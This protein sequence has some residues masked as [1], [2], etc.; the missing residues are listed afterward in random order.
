MYVS[1]LPG[2]VEGVLDAGVGAE[3][4][5]GRVAV[6][7]V[8]EAV[9]LVG[10]GSSFRVVRGDDLVDVPFVDADDAERDRGVADEVADAGLPLWYRGLDVAFVWDGEDDEH[11]F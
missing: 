2:E 7:G 9:D 5:E 3:A 10:G 4:I 6:D 11:P 1:D 8:A